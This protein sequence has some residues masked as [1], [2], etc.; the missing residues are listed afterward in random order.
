M[1]IIKKISIILCIAAALILTLASFPTTAEQINI[2]EAKEKISSELL[3]KIEE[4]K[5]AKWYPGFIIVQLIKG[6]I[7]LVIILLILL[8]IIE[9]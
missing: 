9:P 4:S 8:D 7:A 3:E 1:L 6:A 2:K 5:D